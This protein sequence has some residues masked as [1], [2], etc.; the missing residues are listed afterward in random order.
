VSIFDQRRSGARLPRILAATL[1]LSAAL[2]S[3]LPGQETAPGPKHPFQ[4]AWLEKLAGDWE[5]TRSVR[6]KEVRN[7]ASARWILG[8]QFLELRMTDVASPPAYE[9]LFLVGEGSGDGR[10]VV[11][12]CDSW[13]GPFSAPGVGRRA[14]DTIEFELRYP[15]SPFFNTF[16]W[17]ARNAA[18]TSRMENVDRDGR[19]TLFAVDT[20]R[21]P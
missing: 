11:Y 16:S 6:G 19:R 9:A 1:T 14:G 15:E 17:D 21:R 7:R 10:Y 4:D 2:A 20:Y 18:W 8:H 13:G 12:W 5:I 3:G